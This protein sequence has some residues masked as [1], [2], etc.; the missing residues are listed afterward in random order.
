MNTSKDQAWELNIRVR[1]TTMS[2]WEPEYSDVD[3]WLNDGG[4]L[5]LVAIESV[6]EA[7]QVG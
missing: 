1:V 4:V 2:G 6:Q 3:S 7:K 5:E